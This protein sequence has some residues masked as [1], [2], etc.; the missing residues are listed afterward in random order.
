M[1]DG[2]RLIIASNRDEYYNRPTLPADYWLENR[3]IIGGK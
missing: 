1:S 3:D 2:Y